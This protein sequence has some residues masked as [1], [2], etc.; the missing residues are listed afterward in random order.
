MLHKIS[1]DWWLIIGGA[2]LI[3]LLLLANFYRRWRYDQNIQQNGIRLQAT[4]T[5]LHS[6]RDKR[7][8]PYY[9]M[10]YRV[11]YEGQSVTLLAPDISRKSYESLQNQKVVT[12]LYLKGSPLKANA[13]KFDDPDIEKSGTP[14]GCLVLPLIVIFLVSLYLIFVP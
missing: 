14:L 7:G 9:R 11:D 13:I 6:S 3:N 5:D 12:V 2:L 8:T 4:I 1:S 10:S